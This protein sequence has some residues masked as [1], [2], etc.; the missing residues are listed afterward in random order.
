MI[1]HFI[2]FFIGFLIDRIV[3][4]PHRMPHPVRLMGRV[5]GLLERAFLGKDSEQKQRNEERELFL[6]ALLWVIVV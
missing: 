5:I 4:D 1:E 3:G 2:A 6:G